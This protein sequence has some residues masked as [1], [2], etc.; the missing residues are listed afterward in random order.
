MGKFFFRIVCHNHIPFS[1]G[2]LVLNFTGIYYDLNLNIIFQ[3]VKS[4]E[5]KD[6]PTAPTAR[7]ELSTQFVTAVHQKI[8]AAKLLVG[9]Y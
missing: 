9:Q 8:M 3:E 4:R 6:V 1:L 7:G 5:V 2:L